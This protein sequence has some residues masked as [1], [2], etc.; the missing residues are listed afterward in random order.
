MNNELQRRNFTILVGAAIISIAFL[1]LFGAFTPS[2]LTMFCISAAALV[3]SLIDLIL[4]SKKYTLPK[5]VMGLDIL[6]IIFLVF[7]FTTEGMSSLININKFKIP[8]EFVTLLAFGVV[9]L[10]IGVKDRKK[11]SET[12]KA[13]ERKS[14]IDSKKF[15]TLNS[16][17][18]KQSMQELSNYE[19]NTVFNMNKII[20]QLIKCD[21]KVRAVALIHDG[22]SIFGN[23]LDHYRISGER[24]FYDNTL[25]NIFGEFYIETKEATN[26]FGE[27]SNEVHYKI[28]DITM[29][30]EPSTVNSFTRLRNLPSENYDKAYQHISNALEKWEELKTI[31]TEKYERLSI[32]P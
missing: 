2:V 28:A 9:I 14:F 17:N 23:Y 12:I 19:Y 24:P 32:R 30:E 21:H 26:I 1:R 18:A 13:I 15:S 4:E 25:N 16:E 29:F 7:S 22:W 5:V 27:L 6:A 8:S 11:M 31:A 10:T 20:V 3:Y